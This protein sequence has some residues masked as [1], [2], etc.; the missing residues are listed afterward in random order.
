MNQRND[1]LAMLTTARLWVEPGNA[2]SR[3][4][5]IWQVKPQ[6]PITGRAETELQCDHAP[7]W[8]LSSI[9]KPLSDAKMR[10]VVYDHNPEPVF[11]YTSDK[12]CKYHV[13][14]SLLIY[15]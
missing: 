9:D 2:H 6:W 14:S 12:T 13:Y 10:E 7:H 5:E 3:L 8:R 15:I 4:A 1:L 11:Q